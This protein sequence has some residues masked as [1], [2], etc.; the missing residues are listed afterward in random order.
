MF[1]Q[2]PSVK[3]MRPY[4]RI[5]TRIQSNEDGV[6]KDETVREKIDAYGESRGG[7]DAVVDSRPSRARR[8]SGSRSRFPLPLTIDCSS[9][10]A[11]RGALSLGGEPLHLASRGVANRIGRGPGGETRTQPAAEREREYRWAIIN[12]FTIFCARRSIGALSLG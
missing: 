3:V 9:E 7:L 11:A 4:A 5:K 6:E 12:F 2:I 10:R 8:A 1:R